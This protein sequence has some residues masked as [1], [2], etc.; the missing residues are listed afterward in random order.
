M[1]LTLDFK[2]RKRMME[3][4]PRKQLAGKKTLVVEDERGMAQVLQRGLEEHNHAVSLAHDGPLALSPAQDTQWIGTAAQFKGR[5]RS[6]T[7]PSVLFCP[8]Q[9]IASPFLPSHM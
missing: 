7:A 2:S 4:V 9:R 3:E 6:E 1:P 8:S 5:V